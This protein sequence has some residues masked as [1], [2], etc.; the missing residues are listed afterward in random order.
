MSH[1]WSIRDFFSRKRQEKAL[2]NQDEREE[3]IA[4]YQAFRNLLHSNH[5]VLALMG[6]MQEKAGG[7]Y[8]FD[9]AYIRTSCRALLEGIAGLADPGPSTEGGR[10]VDFGPNWPG[11]RPAAGSVS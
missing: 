2:K 4:F 11:T 7:A 10:T 8:L 5:R 9:S 6:D 3:F 1:L